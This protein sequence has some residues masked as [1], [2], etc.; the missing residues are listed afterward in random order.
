[1]QNQTLLMKTRSLIY[2]SVWRY[3]LATLFVVS[4]IQ[5]P[6]YA[7]SQ[8]LTEQSAYSLSDLLQLSKAGNL[9]LQGARAQLLATQ[10]GS[11]TA[12]AYPN[13]EIEWLRN[14]RQVTGTALPGNGNTMS[15]L[16]P[17][18]N[19]WLRNARID[20][21]DARAELGKQIYRQNEVAA[22][23]EVKISFYDVLKRQEELRA[24]REDAL[25]A[26]QIRERIKVRVNTGEGARFDLVRADAEVAVAQNQRRTAELRLSQAKTKLRIAV[27]PSIS[28]Q[29]EI[30]GQLDPPLQPKD[31]QAMRE[32]LLAQSPELRAGQA[33]ITAAERNADAERQSVLPRVGVRLARESE[34]ELRTNQIGLVIG[35]PLFDQRRGPVAEANA[36]ASRTRFEAEQRR[37]TLEQTFGAAWQQYLTSL[38]QVQALET[39]I[40]N[41]AKRA[42]EIAEAAYRF[43]ERGILEYLDAQRTY[44]SVRNELITARYNVQ[45]AKIELERLAGRE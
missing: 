34:P 42:V 44:R 20:S 27:G 38:G 3:T 1:M 32:L 18:E 10:A 23:A 16:Q 22:L 31:M 7:Q 36:N 17:I 9:G 35:I 30:V 15:I 21:A 6:S 43:G 13:P 8:A 28:D 45:L 39:G 12:R 40:V 24:T 33:A 29:F 4:A 25:L 2:Q 14:Q 26:E 41:N 11:Q 19:P 37:F 5:H